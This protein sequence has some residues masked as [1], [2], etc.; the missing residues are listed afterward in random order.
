MYNKM[1]EKILYLLSSG[2]PSRCIT[3]WMKRFYICYLVVDQVDV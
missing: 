3:K 2:W 1:N